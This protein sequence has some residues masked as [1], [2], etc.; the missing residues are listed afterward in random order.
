MEL[1]HLRYAVAVAEEGSFTRAAA[2]LHVVQQAL[3]QQIAD[4]ERE[5]GIRLFDR[6][7]R[8]ITS[9]AAGVL[10]IREALATL[11]QVDR[12]VK[13]VRSPPGGSPP[14]IRVG[15]VHSFEAVDA[16]VLNALRWFLDGEPGVGL[17]LVEL[18]PDRLLEALLNGR[19]DLAFTH[20]PPGPMTVLDSM[21]VWEEPWTA[22]LLPGH[23][24]LAVRHPLWLRDLGELPLIAFP[25]EVNPVLHGRILAALEERGL[26]PTLAPIRIAGMPGAVI[27]LVAGGVGWQLMIPSARPQFRD[28]PGVAFRTFADDPMPRLGLWL[29]WRRGESSAL[30]R[31]FVAWADTARSPVGA[32]TGAVRVSW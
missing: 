9:T 26:S 16:V 18:E 15:V 29:L 17:D 21:L 20:E 13:L 4:L 24:P 3:S 25:P 7:P 5:L 27:R 19:L 1:R 2:R 14:T 8:G 12:T 22:I 6:T 10:F 28:V 32:G 31:R 11:A 30:L 23:H